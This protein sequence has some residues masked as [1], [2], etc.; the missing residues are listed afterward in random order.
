MRID[1]SYATKWG[2]LIF[3]L[4]LIVI[5]LFDNICLV[6]I[7]PLFSEWSNIITALLD[8]FRAYGYIDICWALWRN[9]WKI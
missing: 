6:I 9:V 8:C 7:A 2:A 4:Y 5:E 3:L 1:P